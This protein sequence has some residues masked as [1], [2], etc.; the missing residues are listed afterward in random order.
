MKTFENLSKFG[1]FLINNASLL[2]GYDWYE[3]FMSKYHYAKICCKCV[4]AKA[5]SDL[6]SYTKTM[7]EKMDDES[8]R[9]VL[10]AAGDDSISV[11]YGESGERI[12][13]I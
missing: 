12:L 3:G 1:N 9:K 10:S 5:I 2:N 6:V 7:A 13:E 8:K 11:I 4:R